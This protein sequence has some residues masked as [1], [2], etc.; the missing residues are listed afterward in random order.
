[1]QDTRQSLAV[2][3]R[4]SHLRLL[5]NQNNRECSKQHLPNRPT[6]TDNRLLE[7]EGELR[8]IEWWGKRRREILSKAVAHR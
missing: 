3:G 6:D 5:R 2:T 1:M 7:D 4:R 8:E